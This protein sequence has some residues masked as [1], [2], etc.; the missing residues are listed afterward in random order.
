VVF[1]TAEQNPDPLE[2]Q[3]VDGDLMGRLAWI[4]AHDDLA[5]DAAAFGFEG[6]IALVHDNDLRCV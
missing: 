6:L 4:N 2:G 1:P 5:D 3:G